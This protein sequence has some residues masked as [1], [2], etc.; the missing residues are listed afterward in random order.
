MLQASGDVE[1]VR[2]ATADAL[3]KYVAGTEW[4][5]TFVSRQQALEE[6]FF[7]GLRLN[8]G[9]DLDGVERQF[10]V[11]GVAAYAPVIDELANHGLLERHSGCIS[12]TSRGR[13]LSNEVFE[14][15][16]FEGAL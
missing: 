9:V 16:V 11:V 12:L 5:R 1:S 6:A 13:L 4:K 14:K 15:F 10:G 8:R 3:E 2:L 7:L